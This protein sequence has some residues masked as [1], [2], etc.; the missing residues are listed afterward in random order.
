MSKSL[1]LS[2]Q[3]ILLLFVIALASSIRLSQAASQDTPFNTD[4]DFFSNDKVH[5]QRRTH[6]FNKLRH[7]LLT[8]NAEQ[9]AAKR[10]KQDFHKRQLVRKNIIS[11]ET[12]RLFV[13]ILRSKNIFR[14]LM[15]QIQIDYKNS[16][17]SQLN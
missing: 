10:E 9:R 13:F 16:R 14:L 6:D 8:S 4:M 3:F 2:N 11:H 5:Q 12:Y 15:I 1:T 17:V 7:F